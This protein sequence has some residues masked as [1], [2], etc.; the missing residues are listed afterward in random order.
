MKR[1]NLLFILSDQYS[2]E[3]LGCYGNPIAKTPNLDQIAE[4]GVR[5]DNAYTN[6]PICIPARASLA[7]GRY[8][9]EIGCWDNSFPYDGSV[10]SWHHRVRDQGYETDAIGKLHFKSRNDDNGFGTEIETMHVVNG[11]GDVL[12]CLRHDPNNF[13]KRSGALN[14]GPGDSSYI[15]YDARNSENACRWIMKHKSGD[16]PWA[17]FLGFAL[18]HPPT[19]APLRWFEYYKQQKLPMP[20]Q[21]QFDQWPQHEAMVFLRRFF[22]LDR[23]LGE[24][25]VRRFVAAYYG[26]CSYVDEQIGKVLSCL[27][28]AGL[29]DSTRIIFAADHGE[30]QGARGVFGKFSMYDESCAI[31]LLMCGPD[32][33]EGKVVETPVS[34]IDIYPTVLEASNI[35][36]DEEERRLPGN[37]LLPFLSNPTV[38]R[39]VFSEYHAVGSHDAIYMLRDLRYK[40]IYHVGQ[41]PQLFDA[42]NDPEERIDLAKNPSWSRK[43][44]DLEFKLRLIANPED[45]DRRAKEDQRARIASAGG[46]AHVRKT[47]TFDNTPVPGEDPDYM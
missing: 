15:R 23:P 26:L 18:P 42:R 16:Q 10:R 24:N 1:A 14:A 40:Y 11:I 34:L 32:M 36:A 7:T 45:T 4:R 37:S 27:Q 13:D 33:P 9:H 30:A 20:K 12:G 31:P 3:V 17:L 46:E 38:D 29:T 47:G 43:L 8:V 2:R 28:D 35:G 5:F 39:T 44:A 21:W 41:R 25:A 22:Q 19:T 6:S